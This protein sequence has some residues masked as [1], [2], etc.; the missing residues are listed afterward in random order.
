MII[1]KIVPIIT[2][3]P[4]NP[5]A[6]KNDDPKI[7]SEKVKVDSLY[8]IIWRIIK[9]ILRIIEM[10]IILIVWFFLLERR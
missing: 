6:I 5:V 8:S 2:C 4:W 7:E 10:Y 9:Y 1:K 3:N